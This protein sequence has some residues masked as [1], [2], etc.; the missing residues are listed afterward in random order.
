MV[1]DVYSKCEKLARKYRISFDPERPQSQWPT[2]LRHIAASVERVAGITTENYKAI[3][4]SHDHSSEPWKTDNLRRALR[5][6]TLAERCKRERRNEAGCRF[7]WSP[8]FSI[9][10]L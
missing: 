2:E 3:I 6:S 9:C 5:L 1:P 4:Q 10:S 7:I 8:K